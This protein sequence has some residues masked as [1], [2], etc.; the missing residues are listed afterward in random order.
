[1]TVKI[2][3]EFLGGL[4]LFIYGMNVMGS[5][6]QK[7]AG[8][9][10]KRLLEI[11]TTK[12][13]MGLLVGALITAIIQSSS[14]TTVMVVG[15]VNAGLM[16][17]MQ[18]AGVIMG[19]NI[20][21]TVTAQLVAFKLTD[22]APVVVAVG[23][24]LLLFG[25]KRRHRQL[26]EILTGF[27]ILF[28]GMHLMSSSMKP[29]RELEAF[30][31]I[32]KG[33]GRNRFLGVLAGFAITAIIQSSSASIGILQALAANNLITLQ[34]ALPILYGQ[35][36]G[37]CVTALIS[38]IGTN[39]NARRAAV[40]HVI[41]N[42]IGTA[43]FIWI[44]GPVITLVSH[45][46]G[47]TMRQ[48]ANAHTFFNVTNAIVQLPFAAFIVM[49]SRRLV[50]GEEESETGLKYLDRRILETPSI[51]VVQAVKEVVR[52]GRIA[53][54]T[55]HDALRGFMDEDEKSLESALEKEKQVN[56]LEREMTQFLIDLAN[57]G[58]SSA[59]NDIVTGLF[60]TIN[61]IER[62]G[63]HAENI[64]EL[65]QYKIDNRLVF[66]DMGKEEFQ[67]MADYVYSMVEDAVTALEKSDFALARS[68]RSREDEVDTMEREL[69]LGHINRLNNHQCMPSAGIVFLDAIS[70]LER[71]G[72]H[73]S[74]ISLAVLDR[75][76][77]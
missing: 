6:L 52:M 47:D 75:E 4:A 36:I 73:C 64:V 66:S 39:L 17:L 22:I 35:N 40:I 46:G 51:A 60:H 21:T 1:M 71:I 56:R 8:E 70:N 58:L 65:S 41:F 5:G 32:M 12:R 24:A 25:S 72:D 38:S 23:V 26:G 34:V 28:I 30:S 29:L 61:D 7:A 77:G 31:D 55:L 19:A 18:A 45:F 54:N 48:I 10:M 67:R 44:T 20:G 37:T 27:G 62:I 49:A 9:R 16:S 13:I 68:I 42:I 57:S 15:F 63:D 69:R 11:L 59:E 3:F 14:A 2:A 53:Q 43:I 50:P 76:K 74:N 33:L